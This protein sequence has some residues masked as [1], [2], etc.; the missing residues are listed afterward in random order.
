MTLIFG[1]LAL[2]AVYAFVAIGYNIVFISSKTFNFAQAQLIMIGSFVAYTGLVTLH[3]PAPVV[4]LLALAVVFTVAAI[5]ERVAIRP[6]KDPHAVL[7]TTLGASVLLDGA[8]QLIWGTQPLPVPFF[9]GDG[10]LTILGGRAYP[11]ELALVAVAVLLVLLL[12]WA[13][14]RFVLGL[15]LLAMSEDREAAML[16]G[17]NVRRLVFGSFACAGALAG[18]LGLFVGPETYAVATL[19]TALALKGF[20]VLAIGGFGSIPGTLV[21]GL[22]VGLVEALAS[23]YLGGEFATIAVFAVFITILMARPAGLFVRTRERAV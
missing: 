4:A 15:A 14:K 10:V 1:G 5:E 12:T 16:R 19:G 22:I 13:S 23:R 3:L 6:L 21:G 8:A 7:V 2:G 18:V 20:V 17:V 11:V 9:G